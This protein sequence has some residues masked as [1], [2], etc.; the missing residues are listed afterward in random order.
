M[1]LTRNVLFGSFVGVHTLIDTLIRPQTSIKDVSTSESPSFVLLGGELFNKGAQGMTFT[2]IDSLRTAFPGCEIYLFSSREYTTDRETNYRFT[3]LPWDED[4][5]LYLLGYRGS[6][7]R[8]VDWEPEVL[9]QVRLTFT[10]S[11]AVFDISGY[12]L[13]SQLGIDTTVSYMT[14]LLLA[15]RY[16]VPYFILPQSIGPFDYAFPGNVVAGT[17]F[18]TYLPTASLIC[19]R[20]RGGVA[21]VRRYTNDNVQL[22]PDLVFQRN[23]YNVSNISPDIDTDVPELEAGAV[24]IVPNKNVFSYADENV[25]AVYEAAI[26]QLRE[27]HYTYVL[28]HADDDENICMNLVQRFEDDSRVHALEGDFNAIQLEKVISQFDFIVA[29]RYHSIV[30]AYR[31][32]IPA[33][34][35]SWAEKYRELVEVFDQTQYLHDCRDGIIVDEVISTVRSMDEMHLEEQEQIRTTYQSMRSNGSV[36]DDVVKRLQSP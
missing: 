27:N 16:D 22:E 6:S 11:T 26:D 36:M 23:E 10:K 20:E 15:N 31:E 25:M 29:S 4:V 2:V 1:G 32:G 30:H 13:S 17:L 5:K 8:K 9:E 19:P 21:A 7:F 24:G 28:P 12:S 34:V 3:P 33:V 35:V 14:D 18:R